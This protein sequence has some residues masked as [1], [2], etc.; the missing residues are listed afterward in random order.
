MCFGLLAAGLA[1][2]VATSAAGAGI[3]IAGAQAQAGFD[4]KVAERNAKIHKI[5]AAQALARGEMDAATVGREFAQLVGRQKA[6][7]ASQGFDVSA[8]DPSRITE[9]T[10]AV[11]RQEQA[12]VRY[13]AQ[14][15]AWAATE[16]AVGAIQA[17][18]ASQF[19]A[20][21][22]STAA[23][24]RGVTGILQAGISFGRAGGFRSRGTSVGSITATG[25]PRAGVAPGIA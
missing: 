1:V 24:V 5:Q 7:F 18:K 15:D 9:E 10:L 14:L 22:A 17:G 25:G 12:L 4:K 20:N 8:G 19:R 21:I 3:S 13:N 16:A 23:G 6:V 11:G 2:G